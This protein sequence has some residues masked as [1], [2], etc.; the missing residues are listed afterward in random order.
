MNFKVNQNPAAGNDPLR[1]YHG[2]ANSANSAGV[3]HR[4]FVCT[5]PVTMTISNPSETAAWQRR[6]S[7]SKNVK[8]DGAP[9]EPG[10]SAKEWGLGLLRAF[11]CVKIKQ[12]VGERAVNSATTMGLARG[13]VEH[14]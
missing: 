7:V 13:D 8:D 1:T 12:K 9:E 6:T 5:L 10:M 3:H 11:G 2:T 14:V 4:V